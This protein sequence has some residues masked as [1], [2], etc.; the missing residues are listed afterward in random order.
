MIEIR[1]EAA[2]FNKQAKD[3]DMMILTKRWFFD[4]A[5]IEIWER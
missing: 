1:E 5:K 2:N 3:Q 4:L